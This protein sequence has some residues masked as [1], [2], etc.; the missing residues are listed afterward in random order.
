[1]R[2]G[3]FTLLIC[4]ATT[5][6]VHAQGIVFEDTTF[7]Q[8]LAKAKT[9]NRLLFIDC[10]TSWC[11]PCRTMDQE[12]FPLKEVGD[13]F[14]AHFVSLK[15]DME[16]G[17][18]PILAKRFDVSVYPTFLLINTDGQLQHKMIGATKPE[19]FLDRVKAG[20]D[21]TAR[22]TTLEREYLSGKR[23]KDFMI[24][25]IKYQL[26]SL[27]DARKASELTA[28]LFASLPVKEQTDTSLRFIFE[29]KE[30]SDFAVP[31]LLKNRKIFE[32]AMGKELI[33]QIIAK[34]YI[35]DLSRVNQREEFLAMQDTIR[36]LKLSIPPGKVVQAAF[37]MYK[38][39][40]L[41]NMNAKKAL[42]VYQKNERYLDDYHDILIDVFGFYLF[43]YLD[44]ARQLL[45]EEQKQA[46]NLIEISEQQ[47][48]A[49]STLFRLLRG[50]PN[51]I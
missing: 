11:G 1:M 39:L 13:F 40:K 49:V 5:M 46:L 31:H 29:R 21:T 14:N 44:E 10:Y 43:C 22:G 33:G 30:M 41:E 36:S 19:V 25:Y 37:Q 51:G 48:Q 2:K 7:D 24:S 15:V 45:T 3:T 42:A 9:G 8:A 17:E 35:R 38:A 26:L 12:V 47:Q 4:I 32:K 34:K 16:K 6:V 18:G 20:M 28:E 23:D 50:S 27:L